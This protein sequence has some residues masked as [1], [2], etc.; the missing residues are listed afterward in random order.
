M[1]AKTIHITDAQAEWL[2]ANSFNVS[3]L[4]RRI[5]K[6]IMNGEVPVEMFTKITINET[7]VLSLYGTFTTFTTFSHKFSVVCVIVC[8]PEVDRILVPLSKSSE[9]FVW[10]FFNSTTLQ[11]CSTTFLS[12]SI[13]S[14]II[15]FFVPNHAYLRKNRS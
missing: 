4:C 6:K 15:L 13:F 9:S 11:I 3:R 7:A 14:E 10:D 8:L 5:F 12:L 2:E 1:V